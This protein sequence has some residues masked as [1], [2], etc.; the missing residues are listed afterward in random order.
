M[1]RITKH[2][3]NDRVSLQLEGR[4]AGPW[5]AIVRESWDRLAVEA[6]AR[7][8][9]LDL[10]AV[11]FVDADGK[12]LLSELSRHNAK[13]CARDC[14]MKAIVAEVGGTADAS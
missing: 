3:Q 7:T 2:E 8:I 11:T 1:L 10:R 5:V 12:A 4:L 13:F 14:L 6:G 9:E